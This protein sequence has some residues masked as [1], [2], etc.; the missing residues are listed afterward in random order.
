MTVLT[1]IYLLRFKPMTQGLPD[2]RV[3]KT[4]RSN[5]RNSHFQRL[6]Q[7]FKGSKEFQI[8]TIFAITIRYSGMHVDILGLFL[9]TNFDN[10]HHICDF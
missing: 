6:Q 1:P 7:I 8:Y 2:C 4:R 10:L 5:T 9:Q 3:A